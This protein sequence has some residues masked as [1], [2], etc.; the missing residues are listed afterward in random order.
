[1][2]SSIS[3]FG[4]SHCCKKGFQSKIN[5]RIGSSVDPDETVSSRSTLF[6]KVSVLVCR[7]VMVII[8]LL[9]TSIHLK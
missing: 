2:D 5:N 8:F 3:E 1:M 6:S 7:G 4:H 9:S